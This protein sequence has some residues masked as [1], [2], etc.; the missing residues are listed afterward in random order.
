MIADR[1]HQIAFW[2]YHSRRRK[3]WVTRIA[4][5]H[6][7]K[8]TASMCAI[9][10]NR[11]NIM[12]HTNR[13]FICKWAPFQDHKMHC[14]CEMKSNALPIVKHVSHKNIIVMAYIAYKLGH[15]EVWMNP[16]RCS[17]AYNG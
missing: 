16:I 7:W 6:S 4:A 15:C 14:V 9:P 8:S 11:A 1:L 10:R 3:N 12:Q 2:I 17:N 13:K 5:P